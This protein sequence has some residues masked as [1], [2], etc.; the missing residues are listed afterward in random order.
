MKLILKYV[1]N[2]FNNIFAACIYTLCM[3]SFLFDV[4][5]IEIL[6]SLLF[7][8]SLM[9]ISIWFMNEIILVYKKDKRIFTL[10]NKQKIGLYLFLIVSF[11]SLF[12]ILFDA[13]FKLPS[14]N[15]FKKWLIFECFLVVFWL[16]TFIKFDKSL[17]R[18]ILLGNIVISF[19]IIILYFSGFS[20]SYTGITSGQGLLTMN[21]SNSNLA[22]ILLTMLLMLL[23]YSIYFFKY[24]YV[25]L[26]CFALSILLSFILWETGSRNPFIAFGFAFIF[27][28]IFFK[29]KKTSPTR[30]K[31]GLLITILFPLIFSSIYMI[32]IWILEANNFKIDTYGKS[33]FSRFEMW[34]DAFK[35]ISKDILFGSYFQASN[36]TGQFHFHNSLLDIFV[37]Y[38][39]VSFIFVII[40]LFLSFNIFFN[41][42][43][44]DKFTAGQQLGIIIF[45]T[46]YFIGLSES[47][48]FYSTYNSCVLLFV[49]I[50]LIKTPIGASII[51][52]NNYYLNHKKEYKNKP[53]VLILNNVFR[54]GSTGKICSDIYDKLLSE[55]DYDVFVIYGRKKNPNSEINVACT[56]LELESYF[57]HFINKI[58]G[59]TIID[60][61]IS[62]SEIINAIKD[63]K[64]D[65]IHI[66]SLNDYYVNTFRLFKFLSKRKIK[67]VITN[68]SEWNYI[69]A[70]GGHAF[71]CVAWKN[72][73]CKNFCKHKNAHKDFVFK[74]KAFKLLKNNN[75]VF[76][77]VSNWLNERFN[78]SE[79]SNIKKSIVVENGI[80]PNDYYC[81]N[82]NETFLIKDAINALY[83]TPN[84]NDELKGFTYIIN[85]AER[86]PNIIFNIVY[87]NGDV[88]DFD[89]PQNINL[90]GKVNDKKLLGKLYKNANVTIVTSKRETFS[91]VALESLIQGTPVVAF[92]CGG[93]ESFS[94]EGVYISPYGDISLLENNIK[95]IIKDQVNKKYIKKYYEENFSTSKM[96]NNYINKCYKNDEPF[97]WH[98][99]FI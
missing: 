93:L 56:N 64:P 12:A 84:L 95:N 80:S 17:I 19:L 78:Q 51:E 57:T 22:A 4:L 66:H 97:V 18:Y 29:S 63:I 46:F 42:N 21:L 9:L 30:D 28:L 48:P 39:V 83:V 15:Y 24:K 70:C 20:K 55:N 2:I 5:N 16:G 25:K 13:N 44:S 36:G 99:I 52:E 89:L 77:S 96:I 10:K 49:A 6:S 98:E 73:Q 41:K 11:I 50:I 74:A 88:K 32:G 38:G 37:S 58:F 8:L 59:L 90:I 67:V 1:K 34:S 31:L 14:F 85:L 33:I 65:I 45:L 43:G 92:E 82:Q 3:I 60:S 53:K 91:M 76:T 69:G 86:I 87:L 47:F 94:K 7:Y 79:I 72:H 40:Y 81:D 27:F 35:F 71:D 75:L 61:F 26:I 54:Y 62:T 68:H 23:F